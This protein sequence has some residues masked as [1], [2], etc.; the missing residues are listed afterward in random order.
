MRQ[1]TGANRGEATMADTEQFTIGAKASCS[2]GTSGEVIRVI[3]DPVAEAITHLVVEPGHRKSKARIVP[4]SLV[5]VAGGEVRLRCGRDEFD[6]LDPAEETRFMPGA[7]DYP[8]YGAGQVGFWPHY[9]LGG[10]GPMSDGEIIQTLTFDAV[11]H[12]EV[13]VRRGDPVQATDGDIGRVH[14]L[15]IDRSSHHVTHV[16]LQEGHLW[17]RKEVAI[18]INAVT[19]TSDGIQLNISK[20]QVQDLPPVDVDQKGR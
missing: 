9:G 16:L 19:S 4:L 17:G 15:V 18:P 11:P 7:N 3:V 13:D 12:G 5:D 8:G 6:K 14:G 2:D 20:Q 10:A 1:G